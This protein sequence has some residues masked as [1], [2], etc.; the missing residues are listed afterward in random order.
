MSLSFSIRQ[1]YIEETILRAIEGL[2][3]DCYHAPVKLL[4]YSIDTS[5]EHSVVATLAVKGE[6]IKVSW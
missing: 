4:D 1:K 2:D 3:P 5:S 6:N